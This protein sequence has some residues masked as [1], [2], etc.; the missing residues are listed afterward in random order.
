MI[1]SKIKNRIK[2]AFLVSGYSQ[3]VKELRKLSDRQLADIGVSRE[4]LKVGASAYP[5]REEKISQVIPKNVTNLNT[6][7]TVTHT[8]IMPR[9]PKAA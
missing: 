3:T 7:K 6:L 2:E 8:P 9:T 1:F 4:L 5:W